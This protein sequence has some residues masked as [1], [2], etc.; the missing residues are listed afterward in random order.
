[1]TLTLP[2]TR[3]FWRTLFTTPSRASRAGVSVQVRPLTLW[4]TRLT[5]P[6]LT[7]SPLSLES[8]RVRWEGSGLGWRKG[9]DQTPDLHASSAP[10]A[11]L[12][13]VSGRST[14]PEARHGT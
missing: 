12:W 1:M 13:A 9:W 3:A 7:F 5:R 8:V 6:P 10:E 14:I 11:R 4:L 2:L